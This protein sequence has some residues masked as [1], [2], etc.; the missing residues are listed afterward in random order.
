M[1]QFDLGGS[2]IRVLVE[3]PVWAPTSVL[4]NVVTMRQQLEA[5]ETV[6]DWGYWEQAQRTDAGRSAS[7]T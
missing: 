6:R 5:F 7:R 2:E 1:T 4:G 3:E